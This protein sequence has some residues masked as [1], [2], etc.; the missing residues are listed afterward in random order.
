MMAEQQIFIAKTMYGLELVLAEE[1]RQL[2]AKNVQE[3]K[4]AVLFE[5]DTR[6]LYK[7]NYSARSALRVLVPV[8]SFEATNEKEFYAGVRTVDWS[9]YLNPTDTIAVDS[10]TQGD[11]FR[12]AQ[13][14][15]LLTKDAVVDQFRDK[16]SRRPN[17]NVVS[18]HLRI[19]V[20]VQGT[21][22][23]LALDASGDSLHRRGYRTATV[24]APLNEVLAAG[25]ILLSGWN[26]EGDFVDPMCGS[27][28]IPIEAAWMA[29]RTPPQY[30]R[31]AGFGFFKWPN[32]D[33]ALWNEVKQTA[34]DQIR[35]CPVKI[36]GSDMDSRARN[37]TAVN[38]MGAG[39][40]NNIRLQSVSFDKLLRPS[41]SGV[42][43][44]N[45]PYDERMRVEDITTFYKGI[46][47]R[48]K[49]QW[50]GWDAWLI[51]SNRA[52]L[53]QVGLRTSK[54]L[55]LFNGPLE[56]SFHKFEMYEGTKNTDP[57]I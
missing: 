2:G 35:P 11:V 53:K 10:F 3:I 9:Q 38:I 19:N 12:H 25:M 56:C 49:K 5:G 28:T 21:K 46:G 41:N 44:T 57:G 1:L 29:T 45:P 20:H 43:I 7:A 27:G 23:D 26:A 48:F 34:D 36:Y 16:Y 6:I 31:V 50:M 52:A 8:H 51:S 47:D 24:E 30:K 14:A 32:F 40:E 42:L 4:R 55:S 18:P 33:E 37:A 13:F 39:M 54:R 15:A 22:I 17:V